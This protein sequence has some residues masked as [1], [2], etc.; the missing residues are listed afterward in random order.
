MNALRDQIAAE[1]RGLFADPVAGPL[2]VER[3]GDDGLFGPGSMA[4]RV[5]GDVT[6]MMVGGVASLLMQMLHP[7][8]LAGVWD[9]SAF[10]DDMLG[11]L[12]RTA[13]F[14]ARTTYGS[15]AEALGE[16]ARVYRIHDKV[17][18]TLPNGT[19][20][21]AND[22]LAL[23]WVHGCEV[24]CFLDAFIRYREPGMSRARQDRYV[25]EMAE[26]GRRM[27]ADPVPE[28]RKELERFIDGMRPELAHDARTAE[29]ADLLLGQTPKN[30][31]LAPFHRLTMAA[32]KDL[33]P[34]WAKRM[35]GF[36]VN[37]AT[38]PL[39]RMGTLGI[40]E[41]TRWALAGSR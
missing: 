3:N 36:P 30:A 25:A 28:C 11:R 22:P 5:H 14:I 27:G 26:M 39:L 38:A 31:A 7:P 6:T 18:G 10:R 13:A 33:L 4:W 37:R 16:I 24:K 29:V 2:R 41:A 20:Y 8:S 35:H 34:A 19:P 12:R 32:G 17:R 21:R 9:H 23:A 1:I 15:R 40:A